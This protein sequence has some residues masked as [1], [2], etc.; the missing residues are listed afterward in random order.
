MGVAD[1]TVLHGL[2]RGELEL[3]PS[4]KIELASLGDSSRMACIDGDSL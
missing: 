4:L 1:I 3:S 2:G